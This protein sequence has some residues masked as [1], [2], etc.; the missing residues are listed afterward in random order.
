M[1]RN[2]KQDRKRLS[3]SIVTGLWML[4]ITSTVM[5]DVESDTN[6]KVDW[7]V[8]VHGLRYDGGCCTDSYHQ[9]TIENNSDLE[10]KFNFEFSHKVYQITIDPVTRRKV[11]SLVGSDIIDQSAPPGADT[12]D[13]GE[14]DTNWWWNHVTVSHL[15]GMFKIRA[16][17]QLRVRR[18]KHGKETHLFSTRKAS[19][20]FEFSR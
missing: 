17:T 1:L 6:H 16:Y 11:E 14:S 19:E 7:R 5:G 13:N 3:I 20:V 9:Y 10:L 15:S 8:E 4:A 18:V 2:K 12:L